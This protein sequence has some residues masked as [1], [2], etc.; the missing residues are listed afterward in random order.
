MTQRNKIMKFNESAFRS[1]NSEVK[2]KK[3][4]KNVVHVHFI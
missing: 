1:Q 2:K 3:C 4:W